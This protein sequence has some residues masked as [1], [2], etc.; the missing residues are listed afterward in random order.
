MNRDEHDINKSSE[1]NIKERNKSRQVARS[2]RA[3]V[4]K[5]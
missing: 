5:F 4:G 3:N 2:D 1:K